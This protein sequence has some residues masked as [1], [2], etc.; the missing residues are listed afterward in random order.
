[1]A[2]QRCEDDM[3]DTCSR[4]KMVQNPRWP[5]GKVGTP[6]LS[7]LLSGKWLHL[8]SASTT[9][10][11]FSRT[12]KTVLSSGLFSCVSFFFSPNLQLLQYYAV[13]LFQLHLISVVSVS[14]G[15]SFVY[16]CVWLFWVLFCFSF[17]WIFV[18]VLEFP[19]LPTINHGKSKDG[20]QPFKGPK[21]AARIAN[22]L[23]NRVY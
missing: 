18:S 19:V 9:I 23:A 8:K 11:K 22:S 21:P 20:I 16:V 1:M 2:C 5:A 6:N 4:Y 13:F 10:L 7:Y 12:Q 17:C 14:L 15:F 3:V